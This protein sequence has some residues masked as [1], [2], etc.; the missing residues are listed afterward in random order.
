MQASITKQL[1]SRVKYTI[2]GR[3]IV[4]IG[5][6]HRSDRLCRHADDGDSVLLAK[7][8]VLLFRTISLCSLCSEGILAIAARPRSVSSKVCSRP[9]SFNCRMPA[10][11]IAASSSTPQLGFFGPSVYQMLHGL[12]LRVVGEMSSKFHRRGVAAFAA[13]R[14]AVR[15]FHTAQ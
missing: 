10:S 15:L 12:F 13:A 1:R 9:S 14:P 11:S 4:G 5:A 7:K 6:C 3:T 2:K 8:T